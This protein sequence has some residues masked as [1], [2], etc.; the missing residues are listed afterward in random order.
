MDDQTRADALAAR[1]A[2]SQRRYANEVA[3]FN[4]IRVVEASPGF[5]VDEVTTSA[6]WRIVPE[7]RPRRVSARTI[8]GEINQE[9]H[10]TPAQ[11]Q[12]KIDA[13]YRGIE[14]LEQG[15]E[16]V[17]ANLPV[18]RAQTE[19]ANLLKASE[20]MR[21]MSDVLYEHGSVTDGATT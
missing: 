15:Q 18:A 7:H 6:L 19:R 9:M 12:A 13:F 5:F 21:A 8:G 4:L 3:N 2:E 16:M 17:R 20:T 14:L 1:L 11:R 10:I